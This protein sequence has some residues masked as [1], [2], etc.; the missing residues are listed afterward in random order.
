MDFQQ[1]SYQKELLDQPSIPFAD[2]KR[3]MQELNVIN[4]WL[5]GHL[6][7][8]KGVQALLNNPSSEIHIM[9]IGCGGGDNLRVIKKWAVKNGWNMQFTGVDINPECI[10]FAQQQARNSGITFICSDYRQLNTPEKPHIIFSSL[11]CHH[12]TEEELIFLL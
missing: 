10:A 3:N 9:E 2:I 5:G 6:I 12:F 8:L 7:T 4:Q 11:F 1:R